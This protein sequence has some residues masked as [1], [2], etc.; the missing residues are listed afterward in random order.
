MVGSWIWHLLPHRIRQRKRVFKRQVKLR[1]ADLVVVSYPKSGRTWV[2]AM[3]SHAYHQKYGISERKIIRFD[4]FNRMNPEIPRI[5]FTHDSQKSKPHVPLASLDDYR[6]KKV[7][8]LVRDPRDVLISSY[9]HFTKRY[10]SKKAVSVSRARYYDEMNGLFIYAM[11]RLPKVINFLNN[12]SRNLDSVENALLIRYEDLRENPNAELTKIMS[13]IGGE[14]SS[15][16][17]ENAVSFGSFEN[18]RAR[19]RGRFFESSRLHP[20]DDWDPNSFKVRRGKVGA[21]REH[22]TDEQVKRIEDVLA[23]QLVADLG[24]GRPQSFAAPGGPDRLA[25]EAAQH[26]KTARAMS[27]GSAAGGT[28]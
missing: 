11:D 2:A 21:Y 28:G 26:A 15:E 5:F 1:A 10:L 13:F 20:G 9:F 25:G 22:F 19:E 14:F 6:C 8:L 27:A 16:T 3:I 17:I 4:N 23:D 7:L 24:Y 12:W 18:L